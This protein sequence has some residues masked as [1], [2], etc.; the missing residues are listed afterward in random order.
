MHKVWRHTDNTCTPSIK[1]F[2]I[3][4]STLLKFLYSFSYK[5]P[6]SSDIFHL[7]AAISKANTVLFASFTEARALVSIITGLYTAYSTT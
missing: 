5:V 6:C 3:Y 1:H 2:A 7:A 4:F